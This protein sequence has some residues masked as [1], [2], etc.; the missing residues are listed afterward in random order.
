MLL[1][2]DKALRSHL[3]F[4]K[5]LVVEVNR[6]IGVRSMSTR[7]TVVLH[8]LEAIWERGSLKWGTNVYTVLV[9][10]SSSCTIYVL[11][12]IHQGLM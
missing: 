12:S 1:I 10:I 11:L 7:I 8:G 6:A 5:P 3:V 2:L 9:L 4:R